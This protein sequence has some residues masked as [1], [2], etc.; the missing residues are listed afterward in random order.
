MFISFDRK[1]ATLVVTLVG[2]LDH[3][4]A[5]IVRIKIDNKIDELGSQNIIFDFNG[6]NF[7]DSSGIG[8]VMGRYRK[9]STTGGKACV[10]NLK[11]QI[12][13]VFELSGLF[14]IIPEYEDIQKAV[15]NL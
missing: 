15:S 14:K 6:V 1:D 4:N 8:V 2:E 11:P 12:K 7:M 5:E 10:I 9:L 3:H 13:R